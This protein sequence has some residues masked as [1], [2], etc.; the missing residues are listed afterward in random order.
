LI[1]EQNNELDIQRHRLREANED[2][3]KRVAERTHDL[4]A[5]NRRLTEYAFMHAHVLRAPISRIRG[6]MHLLP[7]TQDA[8]EE[9]KIRQMLTDCM[10][11]LDEAART[12]SQKLNEA[13]SASSPPG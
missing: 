7:L 6:L 13:A 12:I 3:E 8:A 11:E 4:A 2:L 5:Q 10:N 9:H 1:F